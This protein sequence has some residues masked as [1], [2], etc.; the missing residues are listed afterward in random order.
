MLNPPK[1]YKGA[2][3]QFMNNL[4]KVKII[5]LFVTNFANRT[6]ICRNSC[7]NLNNFFSSQALLRIDQR[8]LNYDWSKLLLFTFLFDIV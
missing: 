8:L 1:S 3:D 6:T 7:L 5:Q 4:V 2:S